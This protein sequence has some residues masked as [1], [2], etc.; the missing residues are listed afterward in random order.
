M[1]KK[2]VTRIT[3]MAYPPILVQTPIVLLFACRAGRSCPMGQ[4]I[5]RRAR[6]N[7]VANAIGTFISSI[8]DAI[9]LSAVMA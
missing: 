6:L 2:K 5:K 1:R 4:A 8:Q 7:T 9:S 3:V